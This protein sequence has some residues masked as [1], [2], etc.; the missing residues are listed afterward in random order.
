MSESGKCPACKGTGKTTWWQWLFFWWTWKE[1]DTCDGSGNL[2][3][4]PSPQ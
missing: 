1:C 3:E 4:P 2:T